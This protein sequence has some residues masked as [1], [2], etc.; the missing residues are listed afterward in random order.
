MTAIAISRELRKLHLTFIM[1][2]LELLA[3][4]A[5][6]GYKSKG[7]GCVF[8]DPS[9]RGDTKEVNISYIQSGDLPGDDGPVLALCS[10]YDA[11]A[12]MVVVFLGEL[13]DRHGY[14]VFKYSQRTKG[15]A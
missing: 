12:M 13:D 1:T 6:A 14:S 2:N 3:G 4:L 11:D 5:T 9:W 7:R 15:Q 10:E 8:V